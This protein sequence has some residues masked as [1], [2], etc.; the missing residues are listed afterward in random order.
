MVLFSSFHTRYDELHSVFQGNIITYNEYAEMITLRD[1][2]AEILL[3]KRKVHFDLD[4]EHRKKITS[5]LQQVN[6]GKAATTTRSFWFRH[7]YHM[8]KATLLYLLNDIPGSMNLLQQVLSDWKKNTDFIKTNGEYYVELMYM[9]NYT[10]ILHGSYI[11]VAGAFNDDINNLIEDPSQRA[12]FEAIKYL[13]LNKI[14]NKTARYDEVEKL[15]SFMKSK[16]RQ[17]E[18]A[19]NADLNRTVNL[20]LGIACFVLEQYNDALYFTKRGITYF[21]DGTREE[22]SAVASILLLLITYSLDNSRLFD[23]QYRATYTYFY[24]RKKKHPFETALVQCLHRTFYMTDTK[25]KIK[26]YQKAL[27]VFDKNKDDIVQK[28]T[29]S[30]FNYSGWLISKVQRISYREFVEKKVL[31]ESIP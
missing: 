9:I 20:S 21:K 11:Y 12:N 15:I 6:A 22:Q 3:L 17:W 19:L 13:A 30:I 10:G 18:P 26:E 2:Y 16:Y 29:L 5:L 31:K 14:F 23:S 27:E 24:K 7:Y 8:S 28:M 25:Q 4:D 1:M